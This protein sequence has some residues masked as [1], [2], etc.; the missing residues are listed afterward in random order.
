[1][2]RRIIGQ[3]HAAGLVSDDAYL[4]TRAIRRPFA[5]P[6]DLGDIPADVLEDPA[7]L[8]AHIRRQLG[9]PGTGA[10]AM[11]KR[12]G[13]SHPGNRLVLGRHRRVARPGRSPG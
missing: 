2:A 12:I 1:M 6:T 9:M 7:R 10:A 13:S 3:A 8:V 11:I 4:A 5:L